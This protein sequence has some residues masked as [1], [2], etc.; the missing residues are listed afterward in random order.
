MIFLSRAFESLISFIGVALLY[1]ISLLNF[2]GAAK[3]K[4]L[5]MRTNENKKASCF[6]AGSF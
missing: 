6:F 1:N 3:I 2:L 5:V 4:H